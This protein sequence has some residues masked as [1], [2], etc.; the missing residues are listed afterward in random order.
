MRFF[1][2]PAKHSQ[3]RIQRRARDLMSLASAGTFIVAIWWLFVGINWQMALTNAGQANDAASHDMLM[4]WGALP[5]TGADWRI[6]LAISL[7]GAIAALAPLMA[8]RRLGSALYRGAPLS[9]PVAERFRGL[10]R[11]LT[12]N[13]IAG[14]IASLLSDYALATYRFNFSIGFWGTL[15]AAIL[16]YLVAQ[17]IREGA[18]A[19]EENRAFV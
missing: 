17:I 18:L 14:C 3:T 12:F 5:L 9:L 19:A 1:R 8:L 7:I 4:R 11:A 2:Q 6:L 16:A 15:V 13:L 10:A